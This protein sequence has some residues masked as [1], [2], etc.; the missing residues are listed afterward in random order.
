MKNKTDITIILDRSGSMASVKDD[1]IGGFNNFLSEQQKIEGE[2]VLSL[3]QFDDQYETVYLDKDI[4]SA[5]KLTDATFQPRG[6]TALFDAVGRTIISVGQR[7][8]ALSEA[9]RPDKILLVIMTDGFENS[10]REF[11]AAKVGEMIKHQRDVYNWQ[12]MFIGA[13]QDAV[14]SA[15]AINI[16]AAAALTYAANVE[17]TRAAYN[18][19]AKKVGNYRIS[20]NVQ[21]LEIEESDREEQRKAGA[22]D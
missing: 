6:M 17:G 10:S 5:D 2:A 14:L 19:M 12:F 9:E 4:R 18:M 20:N 8:A 7:F 11:N 15:E 1:T 3:V 13:N 21:S 16:P 22:K